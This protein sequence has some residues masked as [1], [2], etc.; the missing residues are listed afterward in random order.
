MIWRAFSWKRSF[1]LIL[2]CLFL[3]NIERYWSIY[4]LS[5][6]KDRYSYVRKQI[7]CQSPRMKSFIHLV[8]VRVLGCKLQNPERENINMKGHRNVWN[9]DVYTKNIILIQH[10]K[11]KHLVKGRSYSYQIALTN[12]ENLLWAKWIKNILLQ[13]FVTRFFMI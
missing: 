1:M 10:V 3:P 7:W 13:L 12:L 8:P 4:A 6:N 11:V 5:W 2:T 9:L